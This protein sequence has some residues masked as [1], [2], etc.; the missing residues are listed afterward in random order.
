MNY[1]DLAKSAL[2]FAFGEL[3]QKKNNG[4]ERRDGRDASSCLEKQKDSLHVISPKKDFQ[5][6][7]QK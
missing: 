5:F 1:L 6:I 4:I 3:W 7:D 2:T